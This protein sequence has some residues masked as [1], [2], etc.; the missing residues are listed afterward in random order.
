MPPK[1]NKKEDPKDKEQ[2]QKNYE[3]LSAIGNKIGQIEQISYL[4]I[5]FRKNDGF[6]KTNN[7]SKGLN[8]YRQNYCGCKYAK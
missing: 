1:K 8:L 6:L 7:I 5:N 3:K 2:K 4:D